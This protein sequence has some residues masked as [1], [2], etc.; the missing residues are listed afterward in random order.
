MNSLPPGAGS[1]ETQGA[2]RCARHTNL[3]ELRCHLVIFIEDV[4]NVNWKSG[5]FHGKNR[6]TSSINAL[7]L[8]GQVQRNDCGPQM[9]HM[10]MMAGQIGWLVTFRPCP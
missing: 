7:K 2:A 5:F 1:Q 3:A 6:C 9:S 10:R 4:T 8:E